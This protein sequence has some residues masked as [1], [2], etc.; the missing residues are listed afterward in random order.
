MTTTHHMLLDQ[1][2]QDTDIQP[3]NKCHHHDNDCNKPETSLIRVLGQAENLG[4]NI[5][6]RVSRES[7]PQFSRPL[8][9]TLLPAVLPAHTTRNMSGNCAQ[10]AA[11]EP[12]SALP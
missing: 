8:R 7:P 4:E 5:V 3:D 6:G 12:A 11:H 1:S 2:A 10:G 9:R